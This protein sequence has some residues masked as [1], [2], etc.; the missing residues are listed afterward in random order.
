MQTCG[1]LNDLTLTDRGGAPALVVNAKA[2]R[3]GARAMT[4]QL[5]MRGRIFKAYAEAI[6]E[7][8]GFGSNKMVREYSPEY[9]QA[10]HMR[11]QRMCD[12]AMWA[13]ERFSIDLD[14][15]EAAR[16]AGE[17]GK[18][19]FRETGEAYDWLIDNGYLR[20]YVAIYEKSR[21]S[22]YGSSTNVGLTAKGW[23][24][25]RKYIDADD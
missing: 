18:R 25:A 6:V 5:T 4:R 13:K 24:V 14:E 23:A 10:E 17:E 22:R 21:G 1:R 2:L 12:R 9:I 20:E 16:A 3:K 19:I 11:A 8:H 7:R 15:A